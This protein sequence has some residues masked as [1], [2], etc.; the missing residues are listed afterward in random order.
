MA[1]AGPCFL[2]LGQWAATRPDLFSEATCE[3]LS[4]LH[5]NCPEH[6]FAETK[7]IIL[8]SFGY[9]IELIFAEFDEVPVASGTIA[10]VYRARTF[11]GQEVA[12]KVSHPHIVR[13]VEADL[14]LLHGFA[15]MIQILPRM[16]YMAFK[17]SIEQFALTMIAQLDF[18]YEARNM[19]RFARNFEHDDSVN[20]AMP[21]SPD[22]ISNNVLV[23]TYQ[24][25]IPLK[26]FLRSDDLSENHDLRGKIAKIGIDAYLRMLL[27]H[28]FVHA[29]LHPGNILVQLEDTEAGTKLNITLLDCGLVTELSD[30][31]SNNFVE[32][33]VTLVE[34]D[35]RRGAELM[36]DRARMVD[37]RISSGVQPKPT[38]TPLPHRDVKGKQQR[39]DDDIGEHVDETEA[40][41]L[42]WR[43]AFIDDVSK[44]LSLEYEN[45]SDI[46]VSRV[47]REL[48]SAARH[49]GVQIEPN[50]ATLVVGT[51]VLEGVG[52][53]LN[54]RLS[55]LEAAL[56]VLLRR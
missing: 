45:I 24:Q 3:Q 43:E 55:L 11:D 6:S 38:R 49:Y 28:N 36:I 48:F 13:K 16:K 8:E 42:A 54:P 1:A 19:R 47:M 5:D 40:Q 26:K 56:P 21:I 15:S 39:V 29:D 2:K 52:R 4:A 22:L 33:F 7:R 17:E 25:G 46:Q 44:A 12:V 9:P 41:R 32:L 35:A 53:Q 18:R 27:I 14:R 31:D 51:A 37:K 30:E 23:E 34:G 20:F 50:F 10:Q